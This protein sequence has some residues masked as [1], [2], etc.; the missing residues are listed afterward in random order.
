MGFFR[1]MFSNGE[2]PEGETPNDAEDTV[3]TESGVAGEA[4]SDVV[5]DDA[6]QADPY[7]TSELS[8]PQAVG[9]VDAQADAGEVVDSV[10][11]SEDD[12][13]V[14]SDAAQQAMDQTLPI[15]DEF[16]EPTL[17]NREPDFSEQ[18]EQATDVPGITRP[19][20]DAEH[21]EG[22]SKGRLTFGQASDQGMVRLNNQDSAF[23]FFFTS[24]T[25]DD[26]PDFGVFIVADGMGGHQEGEKASAITARTMAMDIMN[27]VYTPL[28]NGVDMSDVQQP[29]I[30]EVMVE[31]VRKGND[32]VRAE[33]ADGGTTL[34]GVVIRGE[35]AHIAHVGDSRAYWI[36]PANGIEKIT[37]DHSVVARLQELDQINE[38]EAAYHEQRNVLYRA[39]GQN[40]DVEVDIHRKRL[41]PNAHML[42]CS[43][44][45]WNMVSDDDIFEIIQNT[46]DPQQACD[47]LVALANNN[48]GADNITAILI[49]TP[50]K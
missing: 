17:P 37:R 44:G 45:L 2:T 10:D 12:T 49:K 4:V 36:T 28:L 31:A 38:E 33:V 23:S 9:V 21:F 46:P 22:K 32:A 13:D 6:E 41:V 40:E 39:I 8:T 16:E 47:K 7:A 42:L 50:A 19:L 25:V 14:E 29:G 43:D 5:G 34:T 27:R 24:E 26:F 3:N 1:R 11:D 20:P 15:P 30:I 35:A 18:L 48:G